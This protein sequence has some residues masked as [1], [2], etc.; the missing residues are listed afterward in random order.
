MALN[1]RDDPKQ[2]QIELD[3][4]VP[5]VKKH[6]VKYKMLHLDEKKNNVQSSDAANEGGNES[7]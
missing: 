4:L 6:R 1:V 3:K 7:D 2:L 5:F